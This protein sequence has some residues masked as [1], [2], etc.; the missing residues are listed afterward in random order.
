MNSLWEDILSLG[1][2]QGAD[3]IGVADLSSVHEEIMRQ[4][5]EVIGSFPRAVVFGIALS[6][7]VVDQ[8][9]KP[10][11]PASKINY[12][13]HG[14]QIINTRMDMLISHVSGLIQKRG[15]SA[16]PVPVSVRVDNERICSFFS[17]KLAA[18]QAGFGWIG[19]SCML[20]TPDHGPRVRWGSVLCD[21]PLPPSPG[22]I[23]EQC[24]SCHA[25]VD[26]C[27]VH[28]FTGEPFRE[29]EPREIR[30]AAEKCDQYFRDLSAN[31]EEPVCG[32]CL[33]VCPYGRKK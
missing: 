31:E 25:C 29:G 19:K 20:I 17:H 4:G 11:D 5:G 26:I 14:Y 18:R 23:K 8:L 2:N 32:L 24:G 28:A 3:Y 21:A 27:P 15:Y 7:Q 9:G 6:N 33:Y 22:P 30:Y 12:R 1:R 10:E 13:H 16:L